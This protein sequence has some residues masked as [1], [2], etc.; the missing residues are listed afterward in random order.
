MSDPATLAQ[1]ALWLALTLSLPVIGVA[2]LV[3]LLMA[4][5]QAMSQ[6]QDITIAHLP[7]FVVVVIALAVL[8]GWMGRHLV[9][10]TALALSGG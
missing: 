3:S 5:L 8:G 6:I 10:F 4:L 1:T 7:R 2:A 9:A